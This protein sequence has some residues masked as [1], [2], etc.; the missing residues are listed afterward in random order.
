MGSPL[1]MQGAWRLL[2]RRDV[3]VPTDSYS[4][5]AF[6]LLMRRMRAPLITL[7]S[8]ITVAT[9]GLAAI[10][11][12]DDSGEVYRLTVF[13]A[14]YHVLITA[15]TIGFSETPYSFTVAQ[16]MWVA[17]IIF[18]SVIAWAFMLG[19]FLALLQ[20][21]RFRRAIAL[22]RTRSKVRRLREPFTI[23]VGYGQA[24]HTIASALDAA[25]RRIVVI[26][27]DPSRIEAL[28]GHQLTWDV[29]SVSGDPRNP[30]LL[31]VAGLSH[32]KCE[33]VLAMTRSIWQCC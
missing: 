16:R 23:L 19:T 10:P 13:D 12:R 5:D 14:F 27:E 26:D 7:I 11:G 30:A 31:G 4:A 8:V 25:G 3:E 22:Q 18:A 6:V 17:A 15:S 33:Q 1:M 24:G 29:P 2:R 32:P 20:D 28:I 21:S 9:I